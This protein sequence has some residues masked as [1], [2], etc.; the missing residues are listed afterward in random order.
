MAVG[1]ECVLYIG[2]GKVVGGLRVIQK[3]KE[4]SKSLEWTVRPFIDCTLAKTSEDGFSRTHPIL[5]QIDRLQLM[6]VYCNRGRC[7]GNTSNDPFS[8][9]KCASIRLQIKLTVVAYSLITRWTATYRRKDVYTWYYVCVVKPRDT[10]DN[11]TTK[12][13][14]DFHTKDMKLYIWHEHVISPF[15]CLVSFCWRQHIHELHIASNGS[16]LSCARHS[17][18]YMQCAYLFDLESFIPFYIFISLIIFLLLALLLALLPL[19]WGP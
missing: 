9:C 5:L 8:L 13:Q 16:S 1:I 12:I 11:E 14:T 7:T 19:S 6:A 3:V 17:C 2:N 4:E 18:P 15:V 10:N